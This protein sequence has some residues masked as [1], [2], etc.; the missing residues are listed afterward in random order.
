MM[1]WYNNLIWYMFIIINKVEIMKERK[2]ENKDL[3][4]N[5]VFI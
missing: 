5:K 2:E 4:Y 1:W 3:N